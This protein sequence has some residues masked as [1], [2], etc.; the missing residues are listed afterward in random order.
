M[1]RETREVQIALRFSCENC[2]LEAVIWHPPEWTADIKEREIIREH[3]RYLAVA[4]PQ[5][6]SLKYRVR[7]DHEIREL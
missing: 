3:G 7:S 4:G 1:T 2:G 5:C 6:S